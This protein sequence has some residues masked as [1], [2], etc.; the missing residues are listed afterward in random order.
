MN[1]RI[2]IIGNGFDLHLGLKSTFSDFVKS[3]FPYS[4]KYINDFYLNDYKTLF[5][6]YSPIKINFVIRDTIIKS[7]SK[8]TKDNNSL[9]LD[10]NLIKLLKNVSNDSNFWIFYLLLNKYFFNNSIENWEDIESSIGI[11]SKSLND[12]VCEMDNIIHFIEFFIIGDMDKVSND[13]IEDFYRDGE[14]YISHTQLDKNE[15]IKYGLLI[16]YICHNSSSFLDILKNKYNEYKENNGKTL[17]N[18]EEKQLRKTIFEYLLK[19]L[20]KFEKSFN[21]YMNNELLSYNKSNNQTYSKSSKKLLNKLLKG[22]SNWHVINFNYTDLSFQNNK[23]GI[24]N[25]HGVLVPDKQ[26]KDKNNSLIIGIDGDNIDMDSIEYEFTK[27]FRVITSRRNLNNNFPFIDLVNEVAFYG[28]SFSSAD[29]SYFR[30][31]FDRY[32]LEDDKLKIILFYSTYKVN[33]KT[34]SDEEAAKDIL[35]KASGMINRY[36]NEHRHS[37]DNFHNHQGDELLKELM[38][39]G[40]IE[41][42]KI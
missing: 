36:A 26:F 39:N 37:F 20:N 27:T 29:Y 35:I 3:F 5:N 38:L 16:S 34:I 21:S 9:D 22:S 11:F 18:H 8:D 31:I 10:I 2:L 30:S 1:N 17:N 28:H 13:K 12:Y 14:M 23:D 33:D 24:T 4:N 6:D 42:I 32:D 7:F 41:M 19:E 15:F 40:K 25:I